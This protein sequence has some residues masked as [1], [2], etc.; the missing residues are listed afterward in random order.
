MAFMTPRRAWIAIVALALA[1]LGT[2]VATATALQDHT[3]G[4]AGYHR[5]DVWKI[6]VHQHVAPELVGYAVNVAASQGILGI[7]NLSGGHAGGGLEAQVAAAGRFPGRVMVFMELDVS[8]CCGP[9][10]SLREVTRMVEGRALGARGLSVPESLGL[11]LRDEAG[12]PVSLRTAELEP[13]WDM[14]W[15]LEIP[16]ALH[17]HGD[18][19]Q[20]GDLERLLAAHPDVVFL[21]L[22]FAGSSAD[23]AAVGRLLERHANL[24]VDTAGSIP[25]LGR[26]A[27][28]TRAAVLGYPGHVLLGTGIEWLQGPKPELRALILGGGAP[29]RSVDD[30]RR[31]FEST[32]RFFETRDTAIPDPMPGTDDTVEGLGLPR[33]VLENVYHSDAQRLLGFGNLED[34]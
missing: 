16:V 27:G 29:V 18:P 8:G 31:F 22:H 9:D 24:R 4:F 33:E 15:R 25:G 2:A 12:R 21:A 20:L 10:W 28:P 17:S 6:D 13:I 1:L 32:W 5:L 7:V 14:A 34:R 26:A 19:V 3:R 30:V 23:P 11:D